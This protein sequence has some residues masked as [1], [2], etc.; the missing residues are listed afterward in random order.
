MKV[1][2]R[3]KIFKS[4]A[5][6][7]AG[8]TLL[9]MLILFLI[10]SRSN[11]SEALYRHQEIASSDVDEISAMFDRVGL[12]AS[13][14]SSS[15]ELLNMFVQL[16]GDGDMENYFDENLL[17]SIRAG[18]ILE[19]IHSL[20]SSIMRIC[21]FNDSGDM[22]SAGQMYIDEQKARDALQGDVL[23][24]VRQALEG[25]ALAL[26]GPHADWWSGSGV[27][28][29]SCAMP[30]SSVYNEKH[31]GY[32]LVEIQFDEVLELNCMNRSDGAYY[33]LADAQGASVLED[34]DISGLLE[35]LSAQREGVAHV[36]RKIR[37]VQSEVLAARVE[38]AEWTLLRVVP[39]LVMIRPYFFGYASILAG[40]LILLAVLLRI[41][42]RMA[43]R[44][45]KPLHEFAQAIS[46]V[47]LGN[48]TMPV[49][50]EN[51][52]RIDE[53]DMLDRS[54]RQ[55]LQKLNSSI[56][57]EMKAYLNALQ[58][59]MDPH[60]LYNMLTV[61]AETADADGSERTV[62][63]CQRLSKMLRYMANYESNLV[64]L[65]DEVEHLRVYLELMHDRYDQLFSYE[66]RTQE[67]MLDM[68]V[69]K[70]ILQPLVENCFQHGF[71][72]VRPPW[73]VEVDMRMDREEWT[74]SVK[75]NGGGI[76]E[77]DIHK[78][79]QK[80]ND[81]SVDLAGSYQQIRIGGLGMVNTVL[82]MRL[83]QQGL[84]IFRIE[85]LPERGT[86]ITIGG[87]R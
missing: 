52:E 60:F 9:V 31:Y 21:V 2:A 23:L 59:Q 74:V 44:V 63:M 24:Q 57:L 15:S 68:P 43:G 77:E 27:Q 41:A 28:V 70:M 33:L 56:G 76:S 83:S 20:S 25:R 67:E 42:F 7:I 29:V 48:M 30:L 1:D 79:Y 3:S 34:A 71:K 10:V 84:P 22:V 53:V 13:Q 26:I 37:G 54:F 36:R 32:V 80:I 51:T 4:Y 72:Q 69:P 86:M 19:T 39:Q 73:R 40:T 61:M 85:N 64:T 12:I 5:L 87:R 58:S 8:S 35:D 81:F 18:S 55:M 38:A 50:F 49:V 62:E 78:I 75:D 17:D 47:S 65:R 14:V 46:N 45:S 16:D 66:I 82:R 11:Y 6:L